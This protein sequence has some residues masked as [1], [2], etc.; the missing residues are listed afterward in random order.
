MPKPLTSWMLQNQINEVAAGLAQGSM[1]RQHATNR[2]NLIVRA[3]RE[4][5]NA[6]M[7]FDSAG[8]VARLPNTPSWERTR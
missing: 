8:S 6:G 3:I 4:A 5:D 1:T 7:L 2:L